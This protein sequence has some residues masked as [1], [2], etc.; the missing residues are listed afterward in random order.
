MNHAQAV[1]P[2]GH[3]HLSRGDKGKG[4]RDKSSGRGVGKKGILRENERDQEKEAR[5]K[6]QEG[7]VCKQKEEMSG[8]RRNR[9]G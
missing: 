9:Q 7:W 1:S 8:A 2:Q 6:E 3:M 5:M 4:R